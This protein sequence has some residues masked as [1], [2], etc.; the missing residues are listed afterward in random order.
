MRRTANRPLPSG[1]L[2]PVEAAVFGLV[3]DGRRA[4]DPGARRQRGRGR[5]WRSLT[6]VLYVAVYTPLKPL[7][8][9]NTADR[10]G[11]GGACRR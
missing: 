9:L 4:G 8:T 11:A 10:R 6:F 1:R 7:T 3:L 2:A 5:R